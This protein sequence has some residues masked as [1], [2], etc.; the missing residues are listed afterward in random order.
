MKLMS[1]NLKAVIPLKLDGKRIGFALTGSFCNFSHA[2]K[3]LEEI[4]LPDGI[5][6]LPV[7]AI[8]NFA[9][10]IELFIKS[11]LKKNNIKIPK[12][13]LMILF[14]KLEDNVQDEIINLTGYKKEQFFIF[15]KNNSNVFAEWRYLFEAK[16]SKL[17][18]LDFLQKL[19]DSFMK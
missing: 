17:A 11:I 10:S 19:S 2:F 16:E 13:D 7:P 4:V 5:Q 15:L 1:N 14:Q 6:F 8:V 9:F 3:C 18:N 12:H